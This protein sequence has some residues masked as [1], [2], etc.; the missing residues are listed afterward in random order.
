MYVGAAVNGREISNGEISL[1][2]NNNHGKI[3]FAFHHTF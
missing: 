2:R 1:P 3:Y